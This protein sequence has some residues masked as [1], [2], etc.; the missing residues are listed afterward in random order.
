MVKEGPVESPGLFYCVG[1]WFRLSS[2]YG[3]ARGSPA[4][5][6]KKSHLFAILAMLLV[7]SSLV[8]AQ[9]ELPVGWKV[10][11]L[12]DGKVSVAMPAEPEMDT[13][14]GYPIFTAANKQGVVV[15]ARQTDIDI[16]KDN[17]AADRLTFFRG[18]RDGIMGSIKDD[19]TGLVDASKLELGS[20]KKITYAGMPGYDQSFTAGEVRGRFWIGNHEREIYAFFC[21][22]LAGAERPIDEVVFP[23]FKLK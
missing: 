2:A 18:F 22:T 1:V 23:S 14:E 17:A 19:K 20:E 4:H 13:A 15:F 16:S 10:Y 7:C 9:A 3:G 11:D 21:L 8:N 6:M 12:L 5:K